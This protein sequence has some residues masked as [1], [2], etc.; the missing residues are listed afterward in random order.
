MPTYTVTKTLEFCYGHRLLG[1]GGKCRHLHGHNGRVA[2][3]ITA[4]E[5]N[6]LGLVIDFADIKSIA[7]AWIDEHLDHRMLL[8]ADDPL[9]PTL[10]AA[11]EPVY[12]MDDNPSAENIA[13]LI[14]D[15]LVERGLAVAAVS[16]WEGDSSAARYQPPRSGREPA[17]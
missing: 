14:F 12:V 16:L 9:L 17:E 2:I 13:R 8:C 11:D 4:D 7:K 6:E 10:R 3:E 1:H 5:L 15:A